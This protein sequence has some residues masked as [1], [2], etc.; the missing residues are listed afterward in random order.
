MYAKIK[1]SAVIKVLT[2]LHI[3]DNSGYSPIGAL[4]NPVIR[5]SYTGDP[6]IPG[7]SLKGKMRSLLVRA[8][9]PDG[10]YILPKCENDPDNICCLFGTPGNNKEIKPKTARLQFSDAFLINRE[11]LLRIG[12]IT[13]V[14]S[15]NT[16]TRLTSVANPRSME[17][18]V[19]GAKFGVTWFYTMENAGQLMDDM[20]TLSNGCKLLS[21][22]YL[23]GS[24]TRGYGRI[25]FENF[26]FSVIYG[27]LPQNISIS[28]LEALFKDVTAYAVQD[29]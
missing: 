6:F 23:G 20:Q 15:E 21:M 2:G 5:D 27:A 13:E 9:L 26:N 19:R 17:R 28:N 8:S 4:D 22:D 3:G 11:E 14:K 10:Q 1:I 7:S 12:G 24:G 16:I 25:G 18:V 29:L